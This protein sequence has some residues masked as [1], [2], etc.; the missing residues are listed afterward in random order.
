MFFLLL[1]WVYKIL[2]GDAVDL[3]GSQILTVT[4]QRLIAFSSLLLENKHFV[5]FEVGKYGG[6][7]FCAGNGGGAH[8]Y[9]TVVVN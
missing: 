9:R 8:F 7:Y 2:E 5:P 4:V 6:G 1:N 3:E